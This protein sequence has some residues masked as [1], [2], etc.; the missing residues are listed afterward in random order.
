[1]VKFDTTQSEVSGVNT[2]IL[3]NK[4]FLNTIR[5][6]Y[7]SAI[8]NSISI[9]VE[10]DGKLD[11]ILFFHKNKKDAENKVLVVDGTSP[12]SYLSAERIIEKVIGE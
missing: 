11:N 10:K 1:M 9:I 3:M 12:E 6:E 5:R 8:V 7:P 4:D 2:D